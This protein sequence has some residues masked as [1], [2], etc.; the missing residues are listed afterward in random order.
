MKKINW[1]DSKNTW[2]LSF[3]CH[4]LR[5]TQAVTPGG[6]NCKDD[7]IMWVAEMF[8]SWARNQ[9]INEI[10]EDIMRE[11]MEACSDEIGCVAAEECPVCGKT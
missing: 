2:F 6:L 9:N 11:F 3:T 1:K 7:G 4:V 5:N 10:P 8:Q